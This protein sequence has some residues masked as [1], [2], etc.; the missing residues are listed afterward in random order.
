MNR[1]I[2]TLKLYIYIL[3]NHPFVHSTLLS[4]RSGSSLQKHFKNTFFFAVDIIVI[5]KCL[6][7]C[8]IF[9]LRNFNFDVVWNFRI[10]VRFDNEYLHLSLKGRTEEGKNLIVYLDYILLKLYVLPHPICIVSE[11]TSLSF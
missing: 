8:F 2:K 9:I 7:R 11:N 1:W 5:H 4:V 10:F 6:G 3:K